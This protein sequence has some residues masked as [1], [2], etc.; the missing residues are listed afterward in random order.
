[1]EGEGEECEGRRREREGLLGGVAGCG[2]CVCGVWWGMRAR[3]A[4]ISCASDAKR[5]VMS[6][7]RRRG[8]GST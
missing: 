1:M 7:E 3:L 5:R 6:V 2:V 8:A 4:L